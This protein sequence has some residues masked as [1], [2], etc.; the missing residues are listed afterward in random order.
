MKCYV[1]GH[2]KFIVYSKVVAEM[3]VLESGE[4]NLVAPLVINSKIETILCAQCGV[5]IYC[6]ERSDDPWFTGQIKMLEYDPVLKKLVDKKRH[7]DR[8]LESLIK[9][10]PP[11]ALLK[12]L[13]LL[14]KEQ[15]VKP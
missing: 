14:S 15:E 4:P 12:A 1:C 11:E 8:E 9:S 2:E 7:P 5:L 13:E 6:G 3:T 10:A